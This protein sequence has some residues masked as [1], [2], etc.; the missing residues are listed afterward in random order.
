MTETR[1]Y[2]CKYKQLGLTPTNRT[3]ATTREILSTTDR[4]ESKN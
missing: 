4:L 3:V 1:I 2:R